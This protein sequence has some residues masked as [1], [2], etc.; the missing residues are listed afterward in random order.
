[1]HEINSF[2][3]FVKDICKGLIQAIKTD[4]DVFLI[5]ISTLFWPIKI[6]KGFSIGLLFYVGCR[7]VDGLMFAYQTIK[8]REMSNIE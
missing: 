3:A 6:L 1:M 7:R 5:A 8:K 4:V 2:S